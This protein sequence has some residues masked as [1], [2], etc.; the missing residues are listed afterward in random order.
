MAKCVDTLIASANQLKAMLR[1]FTTFCDRVEAYHWVR[2]S[3]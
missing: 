2:E 3:V 1:V